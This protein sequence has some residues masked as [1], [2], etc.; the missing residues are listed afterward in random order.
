MKSIIL[1]DTLTPFISF[2]P[3]IVGEMKYFGGEYGAGHITK[4]ELNDMRF[5]YPLQQVGVEDKAL[6]KAYSDDFFCRN[7]VQEEDNA[8]CG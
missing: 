3:Y 6:V 4:D 1:S 7:S 2:I 8:S 5:S